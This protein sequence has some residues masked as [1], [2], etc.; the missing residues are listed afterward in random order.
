M[1]IVVAGGL[2]H[3]GSR[4][5]GRLQDQG[6]VVVVCSRRR[7]T[8]VVTGEGLGAAT[9][10]AEVVVDV[11]DTAETEAAAA[12]DFFRGT[13]LRLLAAGLSSGVRHHV[14][15]S[16]VGADR[17]A[18]NGYFAGKVSQEEAV[19]DG[20]LPFTIVRA[21]QF[22]DFVPTVADWLTVDGVVQ[23]PRATLLQP[24]DVDDVVDVLVEVATAAPLGG[25]TDVAGPDR[26]GLEDLV[27][28]SLAARADSRPVVGVDGLALGT[29][30]P[31]SLVPLGEHRTG[32]RRFPGAGRIPAR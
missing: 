6:H 3:V 11:L 8:D 1:R 31:T 32:W 30:D 9:A 29:D 4:L 24:V 20:G 10:G 22:H 19:R 25:T 14:V 21:T 28:A 2:G 27:R 26:F 15:L 18:G 5:T 16:V 7:G 12:V 17:A 13:T 23:V